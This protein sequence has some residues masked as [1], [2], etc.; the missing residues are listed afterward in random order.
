MDGI[1]TIVGIPTVNIVAVVGTLLYMM[2]LVYSM[3]AYGLA[4][5]VRRMYRYNTHDAP[6][7]IARGYAPRKV[8]RFL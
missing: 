5:G 4:G 3:A 8:W 6:P 1:I 7:S 2:A